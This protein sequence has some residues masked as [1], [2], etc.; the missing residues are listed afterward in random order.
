[1]SRI[2]KI[3]V[4]IPSGVQINIDNNNVVVK[5]SKGELSHNLPDGIIAKVEENQILVN[6][7]ND[8]YK[9]LHGLNRT[10][11]NNMVIGVSEGYKKTLEIVGTGYRVQQKGQGLELMLGYSHPV[12]V[13]A[14]QGI[15]YIVQENN[16]TVEGI[17][18]QQVG[19][20]AANIRKL[21]P[22]EPY[23]GKG[24]KYSD[25]QIIKKEGKTGA[26]AE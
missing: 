2:G 10:L 14:V 24:I 8:D 9:A 20:V 22:P 12:N 17:D 3:P 26:K 16:I 21:K 19:E 23:K 4:E 7:K 25:E 6:R 5:G 11:I 1:M 13:D 18:K 15:K